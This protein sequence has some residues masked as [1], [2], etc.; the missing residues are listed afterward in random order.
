M[1]YILFVLWATQFNLCSHSGN[2]TGQAPRPAEPSQN[3]RKAFANKTFAN[4]AFAMPFAMPF[5]RP[6]AMIFAMP[7]MRRGFG[8][9]APK[10]RRSL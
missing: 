9:S 10:P 5:A 2:A 3:L 4:K 6:F 8:A 1:Q 7:H